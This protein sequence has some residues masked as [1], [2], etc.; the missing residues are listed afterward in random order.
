MKIRG[1]MR[2]A[3]YAYMMMVCLWGCS[4]SAER[5][6]GEGLIVL[7]GATLIDGSGKEERSHSIVVIRGTHIFRVGDMG[8]YA[9]PPDA[10]IIDVRGRWIIPGFI[11]THAHMP[12]RI[13][14][15]NVCYTKLLRP[16][17]FTAC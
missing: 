17:I 2:T 12:D 5:L 6:E 10:K 15:Y 3:V 8:Q 13:T 4:G 11:D 7:E 9:F 14:S 1:I 16:I